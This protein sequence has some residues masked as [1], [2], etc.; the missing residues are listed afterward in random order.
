MPP[1]NRLIKISAMKL[2]Q[3]EFKRARIEIVPMIDTIF[4]LLVFFMITSLSMVAL[5]TKKVTLPQSE[6]AKLKPHR[7]VTL[8]VARD[9]TQYLD[10]QK[11]DDGEMLARLTNLVNT[12]PN[13][14]VVLNCDKDLP[15]TA[16]QREFDLAKRANAAHI[17]V[18]TAPRDLKAVGQ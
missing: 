11:L 2:P 10:Q 13:L 4:F 12:I 16:F 5:H 7:E 15:V 3:P 6:T 9:G 18:A 17:M 1:A 8:T 14:Q